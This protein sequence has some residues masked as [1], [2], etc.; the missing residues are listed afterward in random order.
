MKAILHDWN[1]DDALKILKNCR[2]AIR[3]DGRL[4]L[5]E[6][7]LK[8]ANEP[9]EASFMDLNMLVMLGGRERTESDFRDL[10]GQAGFSLTRV[11]SMPVP[12]SIIEC[13]PV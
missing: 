7:L 11:I 10:L 12:W 4:L 8:P 2:R 1:D 3:A 5:V 6:R 9:D 13:K